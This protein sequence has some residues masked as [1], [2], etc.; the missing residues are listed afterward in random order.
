M[1]FFGRALRLESEAAPG[2]FALYFNLAEHFF[3]LVDI[4]AKGIEKEFGMLRGR[5]NPGMNLCFR[6]AGENAG[7]INNEFCRAMRYYGEVRINAFRF[8]FAEF[9]IDLLGLLWLV[10]HD[11]TLK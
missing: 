10:T 7:K 1:D 9:D 11:D 4:F 5:D 6:D 8:F 2:V 3:V